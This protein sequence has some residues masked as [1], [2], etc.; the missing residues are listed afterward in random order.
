MTKKGTSSC[1]LPPL[2]GPRLGTLSEAALS[3]GR[4]VPGILHKLLLDKG[5][6]A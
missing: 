6:A 1:P 2:S 4:Q 3:C 5:N